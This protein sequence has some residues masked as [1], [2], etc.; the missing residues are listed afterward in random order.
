MFKKMLSVVLVLVVTL[1]SFCGVLLVTSFAEVSAND[2]M[3]NSWKKVDLKNSASADTTYSASA[4]PTAATVDAGLYTNGDKTF[5][6]IVGFE[7]ISAQTAIAHTVSLKANTTYKFSFWYRL[8]TLDAGTLNYIGALT[9]VAII[10]NINGSSKQSDILGGVAHANDA[11]KP[12]SVKKDNRLLNNLNSAGSWGSTRAENAKVGT[13]TLDGIALN[14][15]YEFTDTFESGNVTE[16]LV[17]LITAG[18]GLY[19]ADMKLEEVI[20]DYNTTNLVDFEN[21]DITYL[22]EE[23]AKTGLSVE[24]TEKNVYFLEKKDPI[25][26]GA[27]NKLTDTM[28]TKA[29]KV[30]TSKAPKLNF[31]TTVN[32]GHKDLVY[33]FKVKPGTSYSLSWNYKI[34]KGSDIKDVNLLLTSDKRENTVVSDLQRKQGAWLNEMYYF[35]ALEGEEVVSF[36]LNGLGESKGIIWLDDIKLGSTQTYNATNKVDFEDSSITYVDSSATSSAIT[37]EKTTGFD[38][39]E[40]T[41]LKVSPKND[42]ATTLLN[43]ATTINGNVNNDKVFSFKVTP[44]LSYKLSYR[45]KIATSIND[46]YFAT[47]FRG[48]KTRVNGNGTYMLKFANKQPTEWV[49][50]YYSFEAGPDENFVSFTINCDA[51]AEGTIWID[52][53]KCTNTYKH[54]GPKAETVINFDDYE[55]NF[56][57]PDRFIVTE[58][59]AKEDGSVSKA[60]YSPG[61]NVTL[62]TDSI[63]NA[64][65]T[66][67]RKGFTPNDPVLTIP[68]IPGD[69]YE[70]SFKMYIPWKKGDPTNFSYAVMEYERNPETNFSKEFNFKT[71]NLVSTKNNQWITFSQI[72]TVDPNY[73]CISIF[74]NLGRNVNPAVY[75]DDI[76]ITH[77][78]PGVMGSTE[79][80]YC[81]EPQNVAATD[82][83]LN[84]AIKKGTTGVT[85]LQL[86]PFAI[87]TFAA[88]VLSGAEEDE[89][90]ISADGVN[91]IGPSTPSVTETAVLTGADKSKR[92]AYKF[93]TPKDGKVYLV[94]N[95]ASGTLKLGDV[96]LFR[97]IAM[98]TETELGSAEPVFDSEPVITEIEELATDAASFGDSTSPET[99]D[100]AVLPI[101]LLVIT[102]LAFGVFAVVFPRGKEKKAY[103]K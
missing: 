5:S 97:S 36:T 70:I 68:A 76:V 64:N 4:S 23:S 20:P 28:A 32:G 81:E 95:N 16:A 46:G 40:T 91:P 35:T 92:V 65:S 87:Y 21:E 7:G 13:A 73:D 42:T 45:Y 44:G 102:F 74:I 33:S 43:Q 18:N 6:K 58:G 72:F 27:A 53:I 9:N 62:P 2:L 78:E 52:D 19:I 51:K 100:N 85:E 49:E 34:E 8:K 79:L 24:A 84:G 57:Q 75:F 96:S 63:T 12:Y 31:A 48:S 98:A 56:D 55:V 89:V 77:Y 101:A 80:T 83:A 1:S 10:K 29:L 17:S 99:G 38:G 26:S 60:L 39:K 37:V 103:E 41:A 30:D 15:W 22:D 93:F 3:T 59:P 69:T 11:W 25:Y 88:N 50:T 66:V 47:Y 82:A 54:L 94:I 67:R 90:F 61:T 14:T 71:M 86:N